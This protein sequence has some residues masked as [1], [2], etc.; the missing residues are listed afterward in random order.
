MYSDTTK[1][2]SDQGPAGADVL[3]MLE[4]QTMSSYDNNTGSNSAINNNNNNGQTSESI[5]KTS[6]HPVALFFHLFFRTAA[7]VVYIVPFVHK[8]NYVISFVVI[9][10]LLAFDFW[11]VKNISGR[12][13]VGLR[14]WNEI[15]EDGTNSWLFESKENRVINKTDSRI[16]WGA[17]Y[18]APVVWLVFALLSLLS[19]SFKWLLVD[20]VAL[21]FNIANLIGYYK[22]EK[23]AKQKLG[24]FLNNKNGLLQNMIGNVITNKVGSV[25]G[26]H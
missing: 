18:I 2:M 1:L 7:I 15:N 5:F 25:F 3:S 13:L 22:C 19:F 20:V 24:G 16:F 6:S 11:T 14:W 23:D 8:N 26:S 21:S 12:L 4:G 17:L 9:T 10:M